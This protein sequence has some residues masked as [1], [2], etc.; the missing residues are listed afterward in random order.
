MA[1]IARQIWC[2]LVYPQH[3]VREFSSIL[4]THRMAAKLLT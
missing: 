1:V 4:L 3:L 2:D